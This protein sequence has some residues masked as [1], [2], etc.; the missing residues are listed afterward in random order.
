MV[1]HLSETWIEEPESVDV[2]GIVFDLDDTLLD[3]K[4]WILSKLEL[5]LD[6]VQAALRIL[7]EGNRSHLFDALAEEL[8][9]SPATRDQLIARYRAV[10]P[11]EARLFP[12]VRVVLEDLAASGYRIALV[13]DNP[14][15]SQRAKL[16]LAGLE[17]LFD[18][19][20]Y[21]RELGAEKPD[22]SGFR[23]A[24]DQLGLAPERLASVGDN[25]YRDAV[26][27]LAAGY[28][29]AFWLSRPGT[30]INADPAIVSRRLSAHRI[31]DLRQLSWYL[32]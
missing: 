19:V 29:C 1:R 22:P 2:D 25:P 24:A 16:R 12:E 31:A 32:A 27:A 5:V 10:E 28:R 8:Q 15:A 30:F 3:H 17:P 23:A 9:L 18:A 6:D 14:P 7:E 20:V 11:S 13:T 4:H 21:T 26:G